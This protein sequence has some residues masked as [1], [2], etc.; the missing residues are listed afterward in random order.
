VLSHQQPKAPQALI[1]AGLLRP[2]RQF[3]SPSAPKSYPAIR[4]GA[5][6]LH[7]VF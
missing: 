3:S 4:A 2:D 6:L 5:L 7:H 1:F